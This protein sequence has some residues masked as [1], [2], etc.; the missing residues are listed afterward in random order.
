MSK[1]DVPPEAE[2][3][4]DKEEDQDLKRKKRKPRRGFARADLTES[5]RGLVKTRGSTSR[6]AFC[7]FVPN[8]NCYNSRNRSLPFL[9]PLT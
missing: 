3:V 4:D 6:R 9:T 2:T 7:L 1:P 5:S 8:R